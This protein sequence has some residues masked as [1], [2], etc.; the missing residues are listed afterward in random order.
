MN[1]PGDFPINS[2]V[3]RILE[4]LLCRLAR[5]HGPDNDIAVSIRRARLGQCLTNAIEAI[6]TAQQELHPHET[7][8]SLHLTAARAALVM[9]RVNLP[10]R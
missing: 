1:K 7:A 3:Q 5:P 10:T 2:E 9:A 8:L 4:L 6:E